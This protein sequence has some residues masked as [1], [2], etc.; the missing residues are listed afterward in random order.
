MNTSFFSQAITQEPAA[1]EKKHTIGWSVYDSSYEYFES[2]QNGVLDQAEDLGI[3]VISHNQNSNALEMV[4]GS[5]NLIKEGVDAL[6]I[7]PVNPGGMPIIAEF[8]HDKNIPVIVI[9]VGTGGADVNAFIVS[10]N[11]G[12]GI[13]AGEYALELIKKYS[14]PS[15]NAAILKVEE[16]SQLARLRGVGFGNVLQDAGYQIVSNT[17]ANSL[18]SEAYEQTKRILETY[19][20][21]LAVIFSEN[22]RMALGAAQAINEAGKKGEILVIGFDG[23]PAAIEA[24]KRGDMQGTIAQ[25]SY[26]MGELGVQLANSI[27]KNEPITYDTPS[28]KE[29]LMEVYLIDESGNPRM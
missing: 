7:S 26:R 20:D 22:D 9:D 16:T 12:G 5:I 4:I 6:L 1:S 10:D 14:I 13:L 23:E 11:F 8:A 3:D 25:Q 19:G 24:I 21:D 15:K 29:L 2:M 28:T 17:T 18:T 27:F